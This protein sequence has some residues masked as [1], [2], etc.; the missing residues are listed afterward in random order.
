[1]SG[2]CQSIFRGLN[3]FY[4]FFVVVNYVQH[5]VHKM[6]TTAYSVITEEKDQVCQYEIGAKN[7]VSWPMKLTSSLTVANTFLFSRWMPQNL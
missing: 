5:W 7:I 2:K 6:S 1:M 3:K 4:V